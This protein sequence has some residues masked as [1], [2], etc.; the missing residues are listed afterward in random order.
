VYYIGVPET[1]E[2]D[3]EGNESIIVK[4]TTINE[5]LYILSLYELHAK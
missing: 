2:A 3:D 5:Q 4:H 1:T